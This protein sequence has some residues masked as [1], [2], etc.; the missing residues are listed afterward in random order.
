MQINSLAKPDSVTGCKY[1][2]RRAGRSCESLKLA[3]FQAVAQ[4]YNKAQ[5]VL[6]AGAHTYGL[7]INGM[8]E[9]R[10]AGA[11]LCLT[12]GSASLLTRASVCPCSSIQGSGSR[13][14]SVHCRDAGS[15]TASSSVLQSGGASRV[16]SSR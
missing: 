15:P 1:H 12:R 2:C 11:L 4:G 6:R 14:C 10:V 3:V 5:A 8:V 7:L 13:G 9:A 16:I